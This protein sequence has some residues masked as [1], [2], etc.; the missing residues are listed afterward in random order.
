MTAYEMRISD[1]SSD[2]C[3]SDLVNWRDSSLAGFCLML[4]E[5]A[6]APASA[7][8]GDVVVLAFN[9]SHKAVTARLPAAPKGRAWVRALDTPTPAAPKRSGESRVG[10]RRG[11]QCGTPW[12]PY[13]THKKHHNM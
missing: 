8:A 4:R 6:E 5:S 1:W 7:T 11:R 3:S 12:S 10:K 2:V 13:H 9:G